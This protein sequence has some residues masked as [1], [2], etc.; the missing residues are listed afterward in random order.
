[1]LHWLAAR[2][3]GLAD[4]PNNTNAAFKTDTE[5]DQPSG[6]L[7]HYTYGARAIKL[8]GRGTDVLKAL[9]KHPRP[10]PVPQSPMGPTKTQGDRKVAIRKRERHQND[11]AGGGSSLA[12]TGTEG[13]PA[14]ELEDEMLDGD[15][16]MMFFW[17]NSKVARERRFQEA[18]E[19]FRRMERWRG[20]VVQNPV[21]SF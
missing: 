15:E 19:S 2:D 8:W 3:L 4:V 6:L 18:K 21:A 7:L 14:V 9:V 1:M 11:G 12:G 16:V 5:N 13:L 20:E 17:T 10:D